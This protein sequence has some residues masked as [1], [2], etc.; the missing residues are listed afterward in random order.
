MWAVNL[1]NI[2]GKMV[3]LN[4]ST[5]KINGRFHVGLPPT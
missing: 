1:L 2:G 3:I 5:A 4:V